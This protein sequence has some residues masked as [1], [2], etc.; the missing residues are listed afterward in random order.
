MGPVRQQ[1]LS[2]I[3]GL[4][5][6]YDLTVIFVLLNAVV[7]WMLLIAIASPTLLLAVGLSLLVFN[8]SWLGEDGMGLAFLLAGVGTSTLAVVKSF[9]SRRGQLP[10]PRLLQLPLCVGTAGLLLSLLAEDPADA[11]SVSAG[12]VLMG[13]LL[14]QALTNIPAREV[15]NAVFSAVTFASLLS[16]LTIVL[17]VEQDNHFGR[18]VGVFENPNQLGMMSGLWCVL[19]LSRRRAWVVVVPIALTIIVLSDSRG[20]LFATTVAIVGWLWMGGTSI[21][22]RR[23]RYLLTTRMM[24]TLFLGALVLGLSSLMGQAVGSID[25]GVLRASDSGRIE[26]LQI[27]LE[28]FAQRPFAGWGLG[29]ERIE[30]VLQPHLLPLSMGVQL[31][32]VGLVISAISIVL[33][34]SIMKERDPGLVAIALF[35]LVSMLFEAWLFGTGNMTAWGFWFGLGAILVVVTSGEDSDSMRDTHTNSFE[36]SRGKHEPDSQRSIPQSFPLS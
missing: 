1:S 20:S 34:V 27:G 13:W 8:M 23:T 17:S 5:D 3:E 28:R 7:V 14:I 25:S 9:S 36:A 30:G 24:V 16:L 33:L 31:G 22:P 18:S 11:A 32:I 12:L 2:V 10:V 15:G 35:G 21:R 29:T 26:L 19:A 6:L 4:S